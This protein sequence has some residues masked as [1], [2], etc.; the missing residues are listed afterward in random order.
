MMSVVSNYGK[1]HY[2]YKDKKFDLNEAIMLWEKCT[3][4]LDEK[5]TIKELYYAALSFLAVCSEVG[6]YYS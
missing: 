4:E 3:A 5:S 1:V 2:I 6:L